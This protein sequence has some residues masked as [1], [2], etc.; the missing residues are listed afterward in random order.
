M[1]QERNEV[2]TIG[3]DGL[4]EVP[5]VE[6]TAPEVE[7]T[8]APSEPVAD[9]EVPQEEVAP[10][11]ETQIEAEV[12]AEVEAEAEATPE[13]EVEAEEPKA[14]MIDAEYVAT[15]FEELRVKY[16]KK[17]AVDE[18]KNMLFDKMYSELKGLRDDPY[19]KTLKPI[20][21]DLILFSDSMR[22][23][24]SKYEESPS[25]EDI[26]AR[27]KR[28]RTEFGK[29]TGHIEDL[30]YNHGVES[31]EAKAGGDFNPKMQQAKKTTPTDEEQ[32]DRKVVESLTPGYYWDDQLLRKETVH[33]TVK[34]TK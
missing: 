10:Q 31:F 33:I 12:E 26:E 6:V 23:L 21:M 3:D 17:I 1:D 30:L 24:I 20:F 7:Q 29:I 5:K 8:P 13:A 11:A 28:L 4:V 27:Y 22:R 16:D 25:A 14:P 19:R 9:V 2:F 32:A 15:L 34:E 18:H